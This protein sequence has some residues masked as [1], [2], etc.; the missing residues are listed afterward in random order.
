MHFLTQYQSKLTI[1]EQNS[2]VHAGSVAE[3]VIGAIRTVVAFG[4]ENSESKRYDDGLIPARNAGRLK[5][6]FSGLSDSVLKSLLFI[7]SA[8]AFWYGVHLILEDRNKTEKEYT[9]AVLIIVCIAM[10]VYLGRSITNK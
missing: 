7:S 1:R 9:P 8:A 2:Y 4:G 3:E 6:V 5:S 10:N